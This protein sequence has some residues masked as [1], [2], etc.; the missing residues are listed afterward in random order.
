MEMAGERRI[1][2]ARDA[3]WAALNDPEVLKASIPGCESI[4]QLSPTE[5]K[6]VVK[7]KIGPMSAKFA[8]AVILSDLDPP[9]GY[10]M[11]GA[12]QGGAAGFAKGGATVRLEETEEGT[13]LTYAVQAQVGVKM[14]QIGA[15]LIDA[16][17]KSLA[18]QFFTRFAETIGAPPSEPSKPDAADQPAA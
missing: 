8:G 7:V 4:E 3:V 16:T 11:T 2:A 17:A 12:G 15:R 14:A 9:H 5:M 13:L 1:A 10:T 18:D 6:A